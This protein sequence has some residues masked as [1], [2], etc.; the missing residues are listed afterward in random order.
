M[1]PGVMPF[2]FYPRAMMMLYFTS[3]LIQRPLP[4]LI[5]V[6]WSHDWPRTAGP[7]GVRV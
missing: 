6:M 4:V 7:L 2:V 5:Q 1:T 3:V